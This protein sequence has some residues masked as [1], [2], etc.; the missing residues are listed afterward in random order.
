MCFSSNRIVSPVTLPTELSLDSKRESFNRING[1][2]EAVP[3][4][5]PWQVSF[6]HPDYEGHFCGGTLISN[7]WIITAAHCF[8]DMEEI[9]YGTWV[10]GGHDNNV[11]E[12]WE[13]TRT[14]E[15]VIIHPNYD[16]NT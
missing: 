10:M 16:N 3:S 5:W 7:R 1:G 4:S 6:R 8:Y 15:R 2:F 12:E 9:G 11:T 14:P 13:Q